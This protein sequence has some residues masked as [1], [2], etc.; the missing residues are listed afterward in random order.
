MNAC[1]ACF[2][3]ESARDG[4]QVHEVV[5]QAIAASLRA[6][7][8]IAYRDYRR[9]AWHQ[10]RTE[11]RAVGTADLWRYTAD[12]LYII[13]NPVLRAAFFPNGAPLYAVEPA[14]PEDRPAILAIVARHRG[15]DAAR[16]ADDWW[17]AAPESFHVARDSAGTVA[18]FCCLFDPQ[19]VDAR[20]LRADPLT[21]AWCRHLRDDPVPKGQRV[22]FD[23]IELT[24]EGGEELSP[25]QAAIWL[26]IKRTYMELRPALRR[27]YAETWDAPPLA[28]V[29]QQLGF[30]PLKGLTI[31]LDGKPYYT[32]MLDFGPASVDGWLA[33]LVAAELG[34]EEGE[35]LDIDARELV[36]D[37]R[38]VALTKLEFGVMHHLSQRGGKAVSRA[39]LL[40]EVW[41]FGSGNDSNVVDAVV[42]AVRK[43]L[44]D[45]HAVIESVHGVG[46]R[47]RSS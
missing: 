41:G 6:A 40:E 30:R 27:L 13:E 37:G 19:Q 12:M 39:S 35:M 15:P 17:R 1:A 46:Y 9:A 38:R 29:V 2:F 36:L 33:G 25:A 47:F 43:K 7:N 34:V 20:A 45:R 24:A 3:V 23:R 42:H 18:A 32:A 16:L 10:L 14:R 26:H 44:G 4:L 11:V 21:Q 31:E 28:P 5:Q 8:P 22:L